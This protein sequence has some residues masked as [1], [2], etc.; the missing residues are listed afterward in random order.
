MTNNPPRVK[1]RAGCSF[2]RRRCGGA[3]GGYAAAMSALV[4]QQ[5][6][7]VCGCVNVKVDVCDALD[8]VREI[9]RKPLDMT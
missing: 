9:K 8:C 7:G 2:W 3:D 6:A 5:E 4:L 1:P